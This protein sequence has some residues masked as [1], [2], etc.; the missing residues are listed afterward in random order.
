MIDPGRIG[1]TRHVDQ[2]RHVGAS[3]GELQQFLSEKGIPV[4]APTAA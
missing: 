4:K 3:G 1:Q 2:G